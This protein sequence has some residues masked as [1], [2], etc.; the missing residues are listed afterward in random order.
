MLTLEADKV[1]LATGQRSDLTILDGSGV[2]STHGFTGC[3]GASMDSAVDQPVRSRR[4]APLHVVAG[5][6]THRTRAATQERCAVEASRCL[7]CD[8]CIGWASAWPPEARWVSRRC[9]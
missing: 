2:E 6:R 4:C 3:A 9:A 1:I 8:V 7:R 5:D